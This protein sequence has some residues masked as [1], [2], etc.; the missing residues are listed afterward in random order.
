M[1]YQQIKRLA[2]EHAVAVLCE[3]LAVSR[4][5]YYDW[6]ERGPS[7]RQAE[8]AQLVGEL[9]D[10]FAQSRQTYGRPRLA[11]CLRQRGHRLSER[12][13]GRLMRASGLRARSRRRPRESIPRREPSGP[14][15]RSTRRCSYTARRRFG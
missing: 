4:S 15:S 3:M 8:D 11:Y 13:V 10:A 1:R 6:R 14:P 5:G 7:R 2:D 12:R 9:Q